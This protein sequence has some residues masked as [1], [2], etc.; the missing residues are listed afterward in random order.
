[1]GTDSGRLGSHHV[2]RFTNDVNSERA[3]AGSNV[4][5]GYE[6]GSGRCVNK[7]TDPDCFHLKI[8]ASALY[9]EQTPVWLAS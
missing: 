7:G 3:P 8:C 9:N 5:G 6:R 1:M 4:S 2:A